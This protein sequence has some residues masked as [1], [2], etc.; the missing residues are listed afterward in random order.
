MSIAL[1]VP[2]D[3]RTVVVGGGRL[4]RPLW[5]HVERHGYQHRW[6]VIPLI[7]SDSLT[8]LQI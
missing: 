2:R 6:A 3:W 8:Q 7:G 1:A 5:L 4:G